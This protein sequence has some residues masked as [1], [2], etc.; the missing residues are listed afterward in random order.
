M[1]DLATP[2]DVGVLISGGLDSA[3]LLAHLLRQGHRVQPIYV[4]C[5]LAWELVEQSWLARFLQAVARPTLVPLVT[6]DLPLADVYGV[7]WSTTGGAVPGADTPDEAVYLPGRNA[8]LLIKAVL[9][10]QL[11]RVRELALA[12]LGSNPFPD[13]T[14]EFFATY[15]AALNLATGSEL[16]ITRPFGSMSKQQVME[17]GRDD[18]LELTFS[19]IHP[20]QDWH[21][22]ACNKCAERQ[23]AFRSAGLAD[24]TR[25]ASPPSNC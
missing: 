24:P 7:H 23:Q 6:L 8:L 15:E 5:H 14:D 22:G 3:I 2:A 9:W 16:R 17:L 25:Y 10:C 11:Q 1:S 18:P 19:C 21:C 13:A 4:R 12:P 20:Q